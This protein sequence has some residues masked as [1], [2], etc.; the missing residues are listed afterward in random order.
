MSFKEAAVLPIELVK[1]CNLKHKPK[2]QETSKVV[3]KIKQKYKS[4]REKEKIPVDVHMKML[5]QKK[6]LQTQKTVPLEKPKPNTIIVPI[7]PKDP[8]LNELIKDIRIEHQPYARSILLKMMENKD[9]LHWDEY[10]RL[11]V[12]NRPIPDTNIK[13][14]LKFI[15]KSMTIT[16]EGDIPT[17]SSLFKKKLDDIGVPPSWMKLPIRSREL[18][19]TPFSPTPLPQSTPR[20]RLPVPVRR[21]DLF[22]SPS[23]WLHF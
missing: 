22:D 3:K 12:N 9:I 2:K 5:R 21:E 17:G 23:T 20:R 19:P 1:Y 8:N 13:Q 11:V 14:L 16:S 4:I 6:H 15:T 10:N 7:K 18:P